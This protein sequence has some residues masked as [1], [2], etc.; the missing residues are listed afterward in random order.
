MS[1]IPL[2]CETEFAPE[3]F[4]AHAYSICCVSYYAIRRA[5]REV[6]STLRRLKC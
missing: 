2:F 6:E 3:L 4:S 1:I 5:S